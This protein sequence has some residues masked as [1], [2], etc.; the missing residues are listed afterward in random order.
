MKDNTAWGG[1][2]VI[3]D[4]SADVGVQAVGVCQKQTVLLSGH[5][6]VSVNDNRLFLL[7]FNL[8]QTLKKGK[9][10]DSSP[11]PTCLLL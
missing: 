4:N 3:L 7:I 1:A 5:Y 8:Q 10:D 2:G 6:F 9:D 11:F